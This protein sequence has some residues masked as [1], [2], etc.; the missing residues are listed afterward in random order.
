MIDYNDS[1][2]EKM[3]IQPDGEGMATQTV[4]YACPCG[5]GRIVY[6]NVR[7]F[8]DRCA[9]FECKVCEKKYR[10]RYGCGHFW[11]LEEK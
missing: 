6:E 3:P 1:N 8:D 10:F 9:Y 4:V 5:K 7:G 2:A 11:A